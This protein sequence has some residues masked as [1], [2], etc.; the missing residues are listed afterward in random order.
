MYFFDLGLRY[1]CNLCKSSVYLP[2]ICHYGKC[3]SPLLTCR[4]RVSV[5][6]Q[7]QTYFSF[8][9]ILREFYKIT[10]LTAEEERTVNQYMYLD[11][12]RDKLDH[13]VS[14]AMMINTFLDYV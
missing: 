6:R 12:V 14:G 9:I 11:N 8:I 3:T 10:P 7:Y 13:K 4:D 5:F 1:I 2:H